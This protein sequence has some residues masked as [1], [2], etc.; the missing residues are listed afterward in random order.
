M[1]NHRHKDVGLILTEFV[2]IVSKNGC[3]LLNIGPR[4][5]GTIPEEEA[6]ILRE[7]GAWL[8]VNGDA[9][10]GSR[11]W[12]I[13]SEG[14]TET[15]EGHLSEQRNKPMGAQDIRFTTQG[16]TLYAAALGLAEAEWTIRSLRAGA[17]HLEGRTVSR[18]PLLGYDGDLEWSQRSDALAIRSPASSGA[19]HVYVFEVT[20]E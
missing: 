20:W 1:T 2:D 19:R 6:E 13:Y 12:K 16:D 15:V 3:L 5:D 11:P 14:P 4:A 18:V 8:E 9:I 7:I 10:Y 17:E